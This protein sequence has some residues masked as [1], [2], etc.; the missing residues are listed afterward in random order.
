MSKMTLL[1]NGEGEVGVPTAVRML[2]NGE[3][4]TKI[5]EEGIKEVERTPL[6]RCVGLGGDPN[7]LGE[8]ECDAAIMDGRTLQC[9]SVGAL[10][11]YVHAISVARAVMEN[12]PHVFLV[13][14]G[15]A[16]FAR[17]IGET[18][19][20]L[21]TEEALAAYSSWVK[22][23][24]PEHILKLQRYASLLPY[25]YQSAQSHLAKG[26]TVFLVQDD[27]G[28]IVG[29]TSTSGWAYKY[30]GRLGDS[31]VIG[32]GL[33]VDNRYGAAACTHTG[34]MT[35]RAGT[36]RSI[37]AYMKKGATVQEACHEAVDDLRSLKGGYI[38]SVVIHAIDTQGNPY[39]LS[40]DNDPTLSYWLWSDDINNI[41]RKT[42]VR[43]ELQFES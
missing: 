39:V 8:V 41:E 35:I 12:L 37:I 38:G 24:I 42:P 40:T 14:E 31:P 34:E 27:K 25:A 36:A 29:G 13:G 22:E 30:P 17:E 28:N 15:A 6:V 20:N 10:R 5:V 32:A 2:Q 21:L 26:T 3:S 33:Y 1:A 43:S 7:L 19:A 23:R 9:G 18:P 4:G 16:Q 11:G